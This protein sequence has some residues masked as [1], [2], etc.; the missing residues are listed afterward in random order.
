[1][2]FVLTKEETKKILRIMYNCFQNFRPKNIEETT[3]VWGMML[4]DYTYQQISVALKSYIL[5]DTSGFAP[6]IGQLVDMVHSVSK[7]QELNEMEAWSLVSM[8][9]RNSGYR[10]TEEFLK[11]PAIIQRAIGTPEQLHI[12][13]ADEDYNETVVMSNFQRSYRLVLMQKDESAKLPTEVRNLLSN[14]ENPARIEM[15]DRIKQLSNAFDEKSK[16]LIEGKEKKERVVDD[17]VMDTV[18]AELEKIKAMSIR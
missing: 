6:T 4:S 10:Y 17:S 12:W 15:Q 3:E 13:A 14:N 8:A 2:C 9:I 18:H 16:L 5:S 1:V 11:L 7:P